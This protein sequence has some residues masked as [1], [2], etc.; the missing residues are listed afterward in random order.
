MISLPVSERMRRVLATAASSV[1]ARGLSIVVALVTVPLSLS[2]L[3][4][5]QYGLWAT[6][7]SFVG[8]LAF[9]DLGV[10][11]GVMNAIS[12]AAA[13]D[14]R[15][16]ITAAISNGLMILTIAGA[17]LL[18]VFLLLY[19]FVPWARALGVDEPGV[20]PVVATSMLV[21]IALFALQIPSVL[22]QRLQYGLQKGYLNGIVQVGGALLGLALILAAIHFDLGLVGLV[23][24]FMLAPLLATLA[25][26]GVM[27]RKDPTLRPRIDLLDKGEVASLLK[28]GAMFFVLQLLVSLA[29]ASDNL[30]LAHGSGVDAVAS[31]SVHQKL[32]S[33]VQ[34]MISFVMTPLWPAYRDA[35][36]RGDVAWVRRTLAR[37][38]L[39]LAAGALAACLLLMWQ[40]P[41]LMELWLKGKVDADL[42]LA[43]AMCVWI[44][45]ESVRLALA[46]FMNGAGILKDQVYITAV[47]VVLCVTLKI[48]LTDWMGAAGLQY[49]MVIAWVA[50][51]PGYYLILRRW[52]P[53]QARS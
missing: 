53:G 44:P 22:L 50:T 2:Y 14:D 29:F 32:F 36:T 18:L 24:V 37:S 42:G 48:V 47:F 33:P 34:A 28:T 13:R 19:P 20:E 51:A 52:N 9:A 21:L 1:L 16:A 6:V 12:S 45:I 30:I 10:G 35:I 11:Y 5:A 43:L 26:G 31:Y 46:M 8:M 40:S 17:T 39:V 25:A 3:G 41:Y 7:T 27:L 15:R 38:I 49:A 4:A 23:A